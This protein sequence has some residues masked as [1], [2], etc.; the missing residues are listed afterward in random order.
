LSDT[1][2][3]AL[4][5]HLFTS[6]HRGPHDFVFCRPDGG[7]FSPDV[8]RRDVLYPTLD[9][10]GIPRSSRSA[11]FHTFRHSAA[12]FINAETGNLKLSQKFLGHANA[13]LTAN[14]YTHVDDEA[15]REAARALERAIFRDLFATV[16]KTENRNTTGLV[17]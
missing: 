8:L 6:A 9:R 13:E 17:N 12:S 2:K 5:K 7:P 1:L 10:A 16:P 3:D 4:Q 14:V 11:G 15:Q